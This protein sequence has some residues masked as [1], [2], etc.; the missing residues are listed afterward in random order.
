M[1]FQTV[2]AV[3]SMIVL[4]QSAYVTTF[5]DYFGSTQNRR[6][7]KS[8]VPIYKAVDSLDGRD[9]SL[10]TCN[11]DEEIVYNKIHRNI[12]DIT[13]KIN[14]ITIANQEDDDIVIPFA[15]ENFMRH[16]ENNSNCDFSYVLDSAYNY[17][18]VND[19]SDPAARS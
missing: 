7:I 14:Y 2:A 5:Y 16:G 18:Y 6:Y 13:D 9:T 19:G 12:D 11:L 17:V 10:F 1:A 4:A 8:V 15:F 3:A